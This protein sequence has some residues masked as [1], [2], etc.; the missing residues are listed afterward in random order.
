MKDSELFTYLKKKK[1]WKIISTKRH[2][3]NYF[4][5]KTRKKRRIAYDNCIC[6]NANRQ[7]TM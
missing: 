5:E 2:E 7:K 6:Y 1:D 3:L 4:I